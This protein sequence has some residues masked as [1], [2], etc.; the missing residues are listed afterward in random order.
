MKSIRRLVTIDDA[1]GK[2]RASA[3]GP[4]PQ[5]PPDPAQPGA[6]SSFIWS[7]D[8]TPAR[9]TAQSPDVPRTVAPPPGGSLARIVTFPPE[10]TRAPMRRSRT[11]DFC[12]V[13]EG[14]ITLVL[15]LEEVSLKQGD[16]VVQRAS[17]HAW[18]NRSARPCVM[19]ISS[20]DATENEG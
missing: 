2:S 19:A 10:V 20:H 16:V 14:E 6:V 17:R 11:L 3:D 5:L 7:T 18:S 8:R 12:L 4:A 13:L 1:S 9:A 15:D